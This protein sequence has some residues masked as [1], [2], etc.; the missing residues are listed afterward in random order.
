VPAAATR[1]TAND[2]TCTLAQ[3]IV[4]THLELLANHDFAKIK[5]LTGC[6]DDALRAAHLLIC[7]L[8]PRPGAAYAC[9]ETRYITPDVVVRKVRGQ[10]SVNVN[11]DAFPRLRINSLYAQILSRQRGSGL[12]G[13]SRKRAG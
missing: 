10:W 12:A 4:R 7:S 8:N 9:P 1:G 2:G 5:K 3:E 11:A 6:E 13:N